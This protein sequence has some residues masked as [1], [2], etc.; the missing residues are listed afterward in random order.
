GATGALQRIESSAATPSA[1]GAR[2]STQANPAGLTA[3]ERDVVRLLAEGLQNAEIAKRLFL[4]AK[5][6]DHHVSAILAKLRVRTR[7]EAARLA[8]RIGLLEDGDA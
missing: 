5:T 8:G 7:T 6:V 3:R 2:R 1:R 4:S